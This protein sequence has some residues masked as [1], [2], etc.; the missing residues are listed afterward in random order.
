MLFQGYS[1]EVSY[2]K[3]LILLTKYSVSCR[4]K[5][6]KLYPTG[7]LT[8]KWLF[9]LFLPFDGINIVRNRFAGYLLKIK[10]I[11]KKRNYA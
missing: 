4:D 9:F 5:S 10:K 6:L 3:S 1:V 8:K 11:F 7:I 2:W